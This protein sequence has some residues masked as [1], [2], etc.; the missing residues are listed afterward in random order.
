MG[1]AVTDIIYKEGKNDQNADAISRITYPLTLDE[2][3]NE[4]LITAITFEYEP[5]K[6]YVAVVDGK[7]VELDDLSEISKLQRQ[8]P[9]FTDMIKFLETG[10]L[11]DNDKVART[12]MVFISNSYIITFCTYSIDTVNII[13]SASFYR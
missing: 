10:M 5:E 6:Q 7:N 12:V 1:S 11:P 2:Q 4:Q 9:E 3:N 8:C 13:P